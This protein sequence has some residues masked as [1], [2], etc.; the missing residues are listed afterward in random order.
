MNIQLK[1]KISGWG[2]HIMLSVWKYV[3]LLVLMFH[4]QIQSTTV[5]KQLKNKL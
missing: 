5:S 3:S 1:V 4:L 2:T